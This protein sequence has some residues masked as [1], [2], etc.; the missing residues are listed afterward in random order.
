LKGCTL[1]PRRV[2][3][4][5]SARLTVVLPAPLDGAAII[6]AFIVSLSVC[7]GA[8]LQLSFGKNKK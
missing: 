3:S 4:A 2:S 8:K 6:C 7:F 1:Y 5:I